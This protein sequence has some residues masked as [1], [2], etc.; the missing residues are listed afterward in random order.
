MKMSFHSGV[1]REYTTK[2][3]GHQGLSPSV[4]IRCLTPFSPPRLLFAALTRL[5][6]RNLRHLPARQSTGDFQIRLFSPSLVRQ[7]R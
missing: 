7:L 3:I 6:K 4:K 2:N 5:Q 1:Q